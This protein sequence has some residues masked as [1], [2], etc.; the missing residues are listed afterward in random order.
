MN[1]LL[2]AN[3]LIEAK[4]RYYS[5]AICPGFWQW[6]LLKNKALALASIAPV[7][8]ELTKGH[9]DLAGWAKDNSGFFHTTT[10][11]DTQLTKRGQIYF[12][13]NKSVPFFKRKFII[14]NVCQELDVPFMNTFE[15]LHRLEARFVLPA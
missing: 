4:N 2:D 13:E 12:L 15:L 9:D 8:D 6:L 5:M 3:T 7:M 11:Q 14:P 10:D 1:H